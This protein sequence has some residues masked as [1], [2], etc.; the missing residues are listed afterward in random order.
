MKDKRQRIAVTWPFAAVYSDPSIAASI[1][2]A[3]ANSLGMPY[4]APNMMHPQ[5]PMIPT[6]ASHQYAYGYHRYMP[7]QMH[8]RNT[9]GLPSLAHPHMLPLSSSSPNETAFTR[10]DSCL[11]NDYFENSSSTSPTNSL[12]SIPDVE[13][14]KLLSIVQNQ[15]ALSRITGNINIFYCFFFSRC[16]FYHNRIQ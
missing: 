15:S 7:Y 12:S 8:H 16:H 3:A 9:A 13:K 6:E 11:E 14:V 1:L 4:C 2:Q 10:L 5:L